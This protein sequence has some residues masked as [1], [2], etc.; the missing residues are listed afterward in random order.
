MT[1]LP[2]YAPAPIGNL[3]AEQTKILAYLA[4]RHAEGMEVVPVHWLLIDL[5]GVSGHKGFDNGSHRIQQQNPSA[6]ASL[7][8]SLRRLRKR[9]MIIERMGVV[10]RKEHSEGFPTRFNDPIEVRSCMGYALA[11][12]PVS[13]YTAQLNARRLAEFG[14]GSTKE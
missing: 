14:R 5:Y 3:S 6:K 8:R 9:G 10:L 1:R 11:E 7:F 13:D 2:K 4:D 12:E